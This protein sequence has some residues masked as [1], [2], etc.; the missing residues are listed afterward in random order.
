MAQNVDFSK[1]AKDFN[2]INRGLKDVVDY[3]KQ[4]KNLQAE[5][6]RS[7]E[8]QKDVLSD[9]LDRT[10]D[11]FKNRKDITEEQLTSVD[12]HKLERRLIAEG[13]E[14]QVKFVQQLKEEDRIQKQINRTINAQAKVYNNI[15]SSIDSFIRKIP[16]GGFLG[17]LLGTGDLG[18]EM[19]E[20]FRTEISKG[21]GLGEFG[22]NV[23][24]EFG[25][26]FLTSLFYK[27]GNK[28]KEG[29]AGVA[30]SKIAAREFFTGG[31]KS[32]FVTVG[33]FAAATKLFSIGLS[34]GFQ[35]QG[36]MQAI[37]RLFA[38]GAF[39][40]IRSALGTGAKAEAGTLRRL[41]MNKFRFGV[42]EADQA[43]ILAAQVNI[44]GLSQ[45]SALNI[46]QSLASS[47]AMRGVLP[48][49]V[50][51]DIANNTEQFAT[52]AKDGGQNIGEAAIR[53]RELGVSLDT[54]FKISDGILDFQ[55]SIENELKA[56]LLI[57]RQLNL[58]EARRLAMAGDMAGLQDEILRQVGSEEELQR[59]NAIQRKSLAGA[60]GVTVTELNKLASGELEVKNSDMKQNTSALQA[61]TFAIG[62]LAVGLGV[63]VAG[64]TLAYG[65]KLISEGGFSNVMTQAPKGGINIGGKFYKGG[66]YLPS[67]AR[68]P[69]ANAPGTIGG[70][71]LGIAAR[72]GQVGII[73]AAIGG[74]T[75]L[76]KKL[77]DSSDETAKNTKKSITGK[78]F[79]TPLYSST[80]MQANIGSE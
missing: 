3:T 54:V 32:A 49:D 58:N 19:S 12:L 21:G 6:S 65:S 31:M 57:G 13:L 62:A 67:S 26:G 40:G 66:Q 73:I 7:N 24:G 14:D 63:K 1:T 38:G 27:G 48:E 8:R 69:V 53:A 79:S 34:Q 25:G 22:K 17:D 51:Q 35:S 45:K 28:D 41:V 46:Q 75:M 39:E 71:A 64:R 70:R 18:K 4:L 68:I 43:K 23:G 36:P 80:I 29:T 2:E 61:L 47:A 33:V 78:N 20:S 60:L 30:K 37:K 42:S 74:I 10:K 52:F 44:A 77:V 50:F 11:I 72:A 15:G 56:S 55:S 76:V 59:M 16:G 5:Y 9:V